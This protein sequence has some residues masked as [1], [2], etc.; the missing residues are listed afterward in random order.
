MSSTHPQC[1][2]CGK[3]IA[4]VTQLRM[5]MMVHEEPQFKCRYCGK[6]LKTAV[7]LEY[8]EREHRGE[9]PYQ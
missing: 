5:H 7:N 8:H 1:K 4:N 3:R 9:K 2:V 6:M